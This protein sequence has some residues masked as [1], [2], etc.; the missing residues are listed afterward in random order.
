MVLK[1][2]ESTFKKKEKEENKEGQKKQLKERK[3]EKIMGLKEK[4]IYGSEMQRE[5]ELKGRHDIKKN[6]PVSKN[7]R[8]QRLE[9]WKNV[10]S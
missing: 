2:F 1:I 9:K 10:N 7:F 8:I 3:Q 5:K 6:Y 4:N